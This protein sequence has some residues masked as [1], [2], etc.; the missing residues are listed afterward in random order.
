MFSELN[1]RG[2]LRH[3]VQILFA[4]LVLYIGI[5]FI[6][7]VGQVENG[8]LTG[9]S[10]P[11]GVEAF[12]PIS[13]L[14][15]LK[16]WLSTGNFDPIHPAGLV[17]FLAIITLSVLFKRTFCSWICPIGT[18]S[19]MLAKL[20]KR[21]FGRNFLIPTWLDYLLRSV[22]YLI[23][24]FF[25]WV[26]FFAMSGAS[27]AEFVQTPYNRVSDIKMLQFM[28]HL[29]VVGTTVIAFI[30]VLSI[31]FENFWCRYL[32][33]YGGLL[34][35]ISVISPYKIRRNQKSCIQCGKCTI[36]CPNHILVEQ[37]SQVWSPECTGCL[38]CVT[39]CPVKNT[40]TF[41]T[42]FGLPSLS[43]KTLAL[44][45]VG[46]WLMFIIIG[47]LTG[48]WE[49]NMTPEMYQRLLPLVNQIG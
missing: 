28:Q 20:G 9:V 2:W 14:V 35:L 3:L 1:K 21:V 49:S 19:E 29:T 44:C 31:F 26:I 38:N 34:G 45:V 43:L 23:L 39:Q 15:G 24:F 16:A 42:P 13:A 27:A 12:L 46:L 18:L 48:H 10:R 8:A 17:T 40:L 37:A 30:V 36:S 25:I 6:V 7:F 4:A 41:K 32:C 22:K 33:P 47:K 11:A 5:T